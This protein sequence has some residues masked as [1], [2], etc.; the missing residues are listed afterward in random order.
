MP[1]RLPTGSGEVTVVGPGGAAVESVDGAPVD[2]A[3]GVSAGFFAA[4]AA[5]G[6][7]VIAT[8]ADASGV[9]AR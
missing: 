8:V 6:G 4:A 5:D 1:E 9:F 2:R 7:A 3:E